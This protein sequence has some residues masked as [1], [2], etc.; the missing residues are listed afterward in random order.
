MLALSGELDS[1]GRACA[2]TLPGYQLHFA[3]A[4]DL[5]STSGS[6]YGDTFDRPSPASMSIIIL[7][8]GQTCSWYRVLILSVAMG[9][10]RL[11]RAARRKRIS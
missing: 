6:G 3:I 4:A 2:A 1:D 8:V 9:L 7:R 10:S 5:P 11:V